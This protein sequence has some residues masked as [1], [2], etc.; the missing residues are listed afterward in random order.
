MLRD[1]EAA[2]VEH[3]AAILE[4]RRAA[5]D[6]GAVDGGVELGKADVAEKLAAV[7]EIRE[8]PLVLEGFARDR[9]IVDELVAH[10]LA[11]ELVLGQFAGDEIAICQFR[12][13]AHAMD[14]HD[15]LETL[16]GLGILDHAHEGGQ[17]GAGRQQV[18]VLAGLEVVQHQGARGFLADHDGIAFLQVLQARGQRAVG[19][20]DAEEF[21]MLLVV[22]ARDAVGASQRPAL[23]LQPDHHEL[24]VG[25][26]QCAVPRGAEAEQGIVPVVHAQNALGRQVA[27]FGS[28]S[29]PVS[30]GAILMSGAKLM[31]G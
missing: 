3:L 15:A 8:A 13:R 6:H 27:H 16:I 7:D 17:P 1:V 29:N 31:R 19:H 25:E 23:H 5:A 11:E 22:R 12:H 10:E 24:A 28:C 21:E 9:R 20:L 4:H 18:E 30:D 2:R 14:E 26:A